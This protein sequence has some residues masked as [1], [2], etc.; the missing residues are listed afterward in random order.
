MSD[1]VREEH[2]VRRLIALRQHDGR[3]DVGHL[4]VLVRD[5]PD[6]PRA[7]PANLKADCRVS[8][9]VDERGG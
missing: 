1:K 9:E 7:A 2:T 8:V 5:I 6:V 3:V 4:E